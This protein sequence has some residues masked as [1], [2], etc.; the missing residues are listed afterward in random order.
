MVMVNLFMLF[1]EMVQYMKENGKINKYHG[2]GKYVSYMKE[3]GKM[4]SASGAVYEGEYKDNK[5][6][7]HG[8]YVSASGAVYEG[9][10]KDNKYHGHNM[11]MVNMLMPLVM[12]MKENG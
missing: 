3:N 7:G 12:Y 10:Y 6:H 2:H 8:K 4:V 5:Y 1:V 11:V 9:E